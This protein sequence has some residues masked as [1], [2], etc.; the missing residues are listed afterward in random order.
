MTRLWLLALPLALATAYA[1]PRLK[2]KTERT[3]ENAMLQDAMV[4]VNK[5]CDSKIIATWDWESFH[6]QIRDGS[7]HVGL[8]CATA[9]DKVDRMC[10]TED[11]QVKQAIQ[12][13]LT[14]FQCAGGGGKSGRLEMRGKVLCM[15]TSLENDTQ[16]DVRKFLLEHL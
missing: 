10:R 7:K 3:E 14:E 13:N 16:V 12:K 15:K 11:D 4:R 8:Y 9:L 5:S 6:G 2:E 1:E